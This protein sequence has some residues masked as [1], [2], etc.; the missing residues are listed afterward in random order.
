M[1]FPR[2]YPDEPTLSLLIRAGRHLGLALPKLIKDIFHAD[3][4]SVNFNR[5]LYLRSISA[6]TRIDQNSFLFNHTYFPYV[7][8]FLPPR[9]VNE[10]RSG[11]FDGS[12]VANAPYHFLGG[13]KQKT[14]FR[15]R[16]CVEC[17]ESDV[18]QYGETYWHRRH[19]LPGVFMCLTHCRPLLE[20]DIPA[21]SN[22]MRH[23]NYLP[24]DT[25]GK[26]FPLLIDNVK[27]KKIAQASIAML[28]G[29]VVN[30]E[31]LISRY[32]KLL[33]RFE[34][35]ERNYRLVD[36]PVYVSMKSFY[37]ERYLAATNF[38]WYRGTTLVNYGDPCAPVFS[39]AFRFTT[40]KHILLNVFIHDLPED[41]GLQAEDE[42][43]V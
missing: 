42:R 9:F 37:G 35:N 33:Q 5:P 19:Q 13:S 23:C 17:R 1:Y 3:T 8:A 41:L 22:K 31:T 27:M 4:K 21:G 34:K 36:H 40:F 16:F 12:A 14:Q 24:A 26:E 20:T 11:I 29:Q 7:T 15:L 10:L 32:Q 39:T 6:Y 25:E 30:V 43:R 18:R 28:D 2:P 38:S